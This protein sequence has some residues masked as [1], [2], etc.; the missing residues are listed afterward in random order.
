L[1]NAID[2]GSKPA[3]NNVWRDKPVAM[4][5]TSPGAR[6]TALAQQQ[7][8]QSLAILGAHVMPGEVYITFKPSDLIDEDGNVSEERVA[9]F[10]ES[11]ATRF[12]N[13]I[14]RLAA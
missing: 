11:F 7:L 2:W 6:G 1:K 12:S 14:E 3:D 9:K 13:Y 4:T 8:R 5:G 10:I